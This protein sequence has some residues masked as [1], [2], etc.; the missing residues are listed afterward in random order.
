[1]SHNTHSIDIEET[2]DE[3]HPYQKGIRTSL[4]VS[5]KLGTYHDWPNL[6]RET[7]PHS[8]GPG[9]GFHGHFSRDILKVR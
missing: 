4:S 8:R 1:M 2:P 3:G 5:L 9:D 7:I 6:M